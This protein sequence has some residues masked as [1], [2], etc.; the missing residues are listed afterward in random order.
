MYRGSEPCSEPETQAVMKMFEQV[1]PRLAFSGHWLAGVCE[2]HLLTSSAAMKDTLFARK[3]NAIRDVFCAGFDEVIG[4]TLSPEERDVH[5]YCCGG[6]FPTWCYYNNVVAFDLEG[7]H[8]LRMAPAEKDQTTE[9]LLELGIRC[10]T[11]AMKN[12]LQ[13]MAYDKKEEQ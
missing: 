3:A 1:K 7:G 9:E 8:R 11:Q 2:D 6:S 13:Y 5:Y 4:E 12:I 10:H